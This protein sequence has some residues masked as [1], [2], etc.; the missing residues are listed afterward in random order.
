MKIKKIAAFGLSALM[1]VSLCGGS[2]SAADFTD[3]AVAYEADDSAHQSQFYKGVYYSWTKN[4]TN[5][6]VILLSAWNTAGFPEVIELPATREIDGKELPVVGLG[7]DIFNIRSNGTVRN[8]I[9]PDTV[10]AIGEG[11]FESCK[12]LESIVLSKR[13]QEIYRG[14]FHNCTKLKS[15]VLPNTMR[16]IGISAFEGCSSLSSVTLGTGLREIGMWAFKD[17]PSLKSITIPANVTNIGGTL[18]VFGNTPVT[19]YGYS[20]SEAEKKY[21][22]KSGNV[23]FV[24]LDKKTTGVTIKASDKTMTASASKSQSWTIGAKASNGAKLTYKSNNAKVKVSSSGKVTV[25]KKF[26]GTVKITIKTKKTSKV[27]TLTVKKASNPLKVRTKNQ[28]IKASAVKK[29]AKTF[30]VKVTKAQGKVSY[31]SSKPKYVT[32]SAKG[33]VTIK[34]GT[35][36]GKYKITVTA[37]GKGIY[38]KK[39]KTITITV[40]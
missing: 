6:G 2:V 16:K 22:G 29:K 3:Q 32:V 5:D 15:I 4:D 25:P 24:L 17:C 39:S 28:K 23:T 12:N 36:K 34:K 31:K 38:N 33:K 30:T 40:K 19:V 37:K 27:V 10:T 8:V 13:L 20:G 7:A 1:A 14:A 11:A 18:K 26:V 9:V 21:A 35:P